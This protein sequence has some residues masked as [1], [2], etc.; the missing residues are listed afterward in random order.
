[1]N[2]AHKIVFLDR[3]TIAPQVKLRP[4]GFR[5][6]LIEYATTRERRPLLVNTARGGLVNEADLVEALELGLISGAGFD[7]LLDEPP[8]PDNPLVRIAGR[9]NVIVTPHV[10]WA[11][12]QAQQSLA[13]QLMDNIE[14]F[15]AGSP[16]NMVDGAF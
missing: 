6:E 2:A 4:L 5:H 16:R 9:R 15:M 11:S 14:S 8:A 1:M 10:A 13:D 3:S 7:V 12:D